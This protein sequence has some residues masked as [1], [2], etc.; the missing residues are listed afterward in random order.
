MNTSAPNYFELTVFSPASPHVDEHRFLVLF[1]NVC[2]QNQS[3]T[4]EI[5]ELSIKNVVNRSKTLKPI[6]NFR[7]E[8]HQQ[9]FKLISNI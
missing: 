6:E 5:K 1:I 3:R 2:C 9:A 4:A 7:Q 8:N